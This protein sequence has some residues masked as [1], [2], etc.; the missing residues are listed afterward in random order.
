MG[1]FASSKV[2]S[3][4]GK[5]PGKTGKRN[6]EV[7]DRAIASASPMAMLSDIVALKHPLVCIEYGLS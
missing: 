3:A 5:T 4:M 6:G 1:G 2:F 7:A